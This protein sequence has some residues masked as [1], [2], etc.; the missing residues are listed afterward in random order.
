MYEP[1]RD[2]SAC[3]DESDVSDLDKNE[4]EECSKDN[5]RVG[6]LDWV[7]VETVQWEKERYIVSAVLKY[8]P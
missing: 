6:N 1:E 2:T 5:V 8:M 4:S 7:Y 3:S